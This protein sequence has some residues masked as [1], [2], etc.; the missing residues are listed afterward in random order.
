MSPEKYIWDL[1]KCKQQSYNLVLLRGLHLSK[2]VSLNIKNKFR[3]KIENHNFTEVECTMF[4]NFTELLKI[5]KSM[6]DSE[7]VQHLKNILTPL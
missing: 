1:P 4:V 2:V 6:E 5:S 3:I 7:L